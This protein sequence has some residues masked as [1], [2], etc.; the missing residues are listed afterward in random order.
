M[1]NSRIL[2]DSPFNSLKL[3][4]LNRILEN[5]K[6]IKRGQVVMGTE[7]NKRYLKEVALYHEAIAD[8]TPDDLIIIVEA[9]DEEILDDMVKQAEALLTEFLAQKRADTRE[10]NN[11]FE[12]FTQYLSNKEVKSPFFQRDFTDRRIMGHIQSVFKSSFNVLFQDKLL[13]FSTTGMPV[14]PHGCVL[15]K[16]VIDR[17]LANGRRG[18]LVKME[19]NLVTF[20]TRGDVF[21]KD[22]SE[23][24][25]IDL[26]IPKMTLPGSNQLETNLYKV[27]AEISFET[28]IGLKNEGQVPK[29]LQT[30]KNIETSE[31]VAIQQTVDYLIGRGD[32]LTPSGDDILL[33][34]GM[35]RQ[36]FLADDFFI[37]F[38]KRGTKNRKTTAVS[39][40]YYESLFAGYGN[41]LFLGLI[42]SIGTETMATTKKITALITRYGH[43]SGYDTLFGIY[44]GLQSLVN[45]H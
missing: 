39:L 41:S 21:T 18:N 43:T 22:L 15:N 42:A 34:F 25:E 7:A 13:N 17:V 40:A 32:G 24:E 29:S 5:S 37:G 27:L 8:A 38:L 28:A 31:E 10:K 16:E 3:T 2:K 9:L 19:G 1:I 11:K 45:E 33:G 35:I 12:E 6:R 44:L 23:I 4:F 20:Y 26:S 36:A 30:L 14:S